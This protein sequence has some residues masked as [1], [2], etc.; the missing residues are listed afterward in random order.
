MSDPIVIAAF[1][2]RL[3]TLTTPF[4][5]TLNERPSSLPTLYTSLER[6][7]CEVER[8]TLGVPSQFRETGTLTVVVAQRSGLGYTAAETLAEEV[9]ALFHNY[10]LVHLQVLTVGSPTVFEAD[11]GNYF[12]M[13]VPVRYMFD[14][15]KG[16]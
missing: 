16:A 8:I 4:V 1:R 6:D 5:Q 9:R 14:F 10:S 12:L 11:E 3:E 2:A 7:Y 15:F 13:K